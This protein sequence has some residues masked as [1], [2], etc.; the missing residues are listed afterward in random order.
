MSDQN[1]DAVTNQVDTN[2]ADWDEAKL[3][4]LVGLDS[5]TET[6]PT[7]I[8]NSRENLTG[9]NVV[10]QADLFEEETKPEPHDNKTK[11]P[12]A[13]NPYAKLT[14]IALGLSV[15]FGI[16]GFALTTMMSNPPKL[17]KEA[18]VKP[19]S[20]EIPSV[21]VEKEETDEGKLKT[22]LA[23]STQA[24]ELNKLDE[25][26][27][28]KTTSLGVETPK[29]EPTPTP[30]TVAPTQA[31]SAINRPPVS[32][33][34]PPQPRRVAISPPPP[35]LIPSPERS[36]R[37]S[38]ESVP[39]LSPPPPPPPV[40]KAPTPPPIVQE[41]KA[42]EDQKEDQTEQ[43]VKLASLGSYGQ[44]VLPQPDGGELA[45]VP[46]VTYQ[47][48]SQVVQ[49]GTVV[50]GEIVVPVAITEDGTEQRFVVALRS[51][52]LDVEGQ[53]AIAKGQFLVFEVEGVDSSGLVSVKAV[54]VVD[55]EGNE[56][57]ISAALALESDGRPLV[58]QKLFD[59]G[60]DVAS[61][62]L[63]IF[64]LGAVSK[65][66]EILNRPQ[67]ESS[68]STSGTSTTTSSTS[69]SGEP[70]L[71]GAIMEGGATPVLDAISK[72]N[73]EAIERMNDLD[74]AWVLSPGLLLS[75]RV[76]QPL[77]I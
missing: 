69:V 18:T 45:N 27:D 15:V 73:E 5:D 68:T 54:S 10:D 47:D 2:Q 7:G 34:P 72:R 9:Q 37:A 35:R 53:V 26:P 64:A 14:F 33:P 63:G 16:G 59:V 67:Q 1:G 36:R 32:Q 48:L 41:A 25:K 6:E 11:Q 24:E 65:V 22:Q 52:L 55:E 44:V 61:M 75:I 76:T 62:D 19:S 28:K 43:W 57:A 20:K 30:T 8:L 42:Q 58:A 17:A 46:P 50:S 70:N 56:R 4:A 3:A 38:S 23:L 39:T 13:K 51:D 12:L 40:Q 66:G 71:L 60:S 49:V 21:V 74:N 77:R 29:P 31:P